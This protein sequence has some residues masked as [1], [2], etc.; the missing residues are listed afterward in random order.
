MFS[1]SSHI[2]GCDGA[3]D[4]TGAQPGSLAAGASTAVTL[5]SA[6]VGRIFNQNG[7]CGASGESCTV[8]EYN[9]DSGDFYT[10]QSY[11]I[12]NIQGYTQS[13]QVSA[14]GCDTVTCTNANC[15]CSSAY[16]VGD[17][18]GCGN[19]SPV[20]ACGAGDVSFTVVFCP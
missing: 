11:D 1:P 16:P 15:G 5:P 2:I 18:S 17:T 6:W 9:L 20:R 4:F 12:S 13:I 19:D 7:A 10:P 14:A 3:A 8:T